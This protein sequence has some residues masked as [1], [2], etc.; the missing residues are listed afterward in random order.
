MQGGPGSIPDQGTRSHTLQLK[1]LHTA[2]KIKDPACRNEDLMQPNKQRNT[3]K[4]RE[5]KP[6]E[7]P[8]YRKMGRRAGKE[9]A[10]Q[11]GAEG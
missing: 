6:P 5:R 2:T 8:Y 7:G 10:G 9:K 3:L 4:K 11:A 1:V